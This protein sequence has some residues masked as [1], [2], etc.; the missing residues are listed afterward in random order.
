MIDADKRPFADM[1]NAV[2]TIYGKPLPEKEMLRIWWHKLK[3]FEFCDVA[4]AFDIWTD[5]PNKLPQPADIVQ[6]CKP[7]D[8]IYRALPKPANHQ[9]ENKKNAR[10]LNT[11]VAKE[12]KPIT[13]YQAWARRIIDAPQNYPEISVRFAQEALQ[14]NAE[15]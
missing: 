8:D 2:F 9:T 12:I 3:R 6:L 10:E 4:K 11:F 14:R 13:D 15:I 7:R 5:T 1:I